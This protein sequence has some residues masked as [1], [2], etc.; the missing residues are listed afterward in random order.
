MANFT[1]AYKMFGYN[2]DN[3][4]EEMLRKIMASGNMVDPAQMSG[5]TAGGGI[6]NMGAGSAPSESMLGVT[7]G[8]GIDN[9]AASIEALTKAETLDPA[10]VQAQQNA[11]SDVAMQAAL[12]NLGNTASSLAFNPGVPDMI[13]LQRGGGMM[14]LPGAPD[15]TTQASQPVDYTG[16]LDLFKK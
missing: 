14:A 9:T 12:Q 13:P 6:S 16:L 7:P 3:D 8:A 4:K 2:K 5:M 15:L 10:F 1:K 11:Q